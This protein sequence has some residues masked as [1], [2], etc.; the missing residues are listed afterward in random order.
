MQHALFNRTQCIADL[1]A[2][3]IKNWPQH[4]W[5][6]SILQHF[7]ATVSDQKLDMLSNLSEQWLMHWQWLEQPCTFKLEQMPDNTYSL[8][9]ATQDTPFL[10]DSINL[11]FRH[12]KLAVSFIFH[13]GHLTVTRAHQHV[14]HVVYQTKSSDNKEAWVLANVAGD[15]SDLKARL[16]QTCDQLK[17]A[18]SHFSAM[19][20]AAMSCQSALPEDCLKFLTWCL[21]SHFVLM[22][23]QTPTKTWGIL[24]DEPTHLMVHQALV[25]LPTACTALEIFKLP[26]FAP[27]HR[28]S[29]MDVIRVTLNAENT[30]YWIGLFTSSMERTPL[31]AIPMATD[32]FQWLLQQSQL[33]SNSHAGKS[34]LDI[35]ET[36]PRDEWLHM[37]NHDILTFA[38]NCIRIQPG[39]TRVLRHASYCGQF[40]SLW[41]YFP[42]SQYQTDTLQTLLTIVNQH[43]QPAHW[44]EPLV[45]HHD[46]MVC[47]YWRMAIS[48]D[49][50]CH[51][52]VLDEQLY[53]TLQSWMAQVIQLAPNLEHA[54]AIFPWHY[55]RQFSPSHAV[56]DAQCAQT[57]HA[58]HTFCVRWLHDGDYSMRWIWYQWH[59]PMALSVT[60]PILENF[61]FL[62]QEEQSFVL[63][64]NHQEVHIG[65]F[66]VTTRIPVPSTADRAHVIYDAMMAVWHRRAP[67]DSLNRLTTSHGIGWLSINVLRAYLAYFQQ[68]A[69][70]INRESAQATLLLHA[71][72]AYYLTQYFE[73]RFVHPSTVPYDLTALHNSMRA[74]LPNDEKCFH[75]YLQVMAA[76]VRT[77]FY[78]SWAKDFLCFKIHTETLD[79]LPLPR[80]LYEIWVDSLSFSGVHLRSARVARGG[81][82]WS[83]RKDDFRT[84][85]LGLMK[86]QCVKNTFIVPAGAKGGFIIKEDG[87]HLTPA[88]RLEWGVKFYKKF[89][90]ALLCLTDNIVDGVIIPPHHVTCHDAPDTYL[91]VAADKGTAQFSDIANCIAQEHQFWLDDAFASG[92]QYGYNHKTMGITAAGAWTSLQQHAYT[93]HR[94]AN[95]HAWTVIGI[96]DMAGDVFGNGMLLSPHIQLLAAFNGKHIFLN[97]YPQPNTHEEL[98]KLFNQPYSTWLDFQNFGEGGGVFNRSAKEITLHDAVKRRFNLNEHCLSPDALIRQLLISPVDIIWN[99]GIGTFVKACHESHTQVSDKTNDAIRVNGGDLTCTMVIE[100]GNLGMTQLGRIEYALKG[101]DVYADF[102]DN[103][104]GVSCSDHEVLLKILLKN[105]PNLSFVERNQLLQ[106][107]EPEIKTMVLKA[108]QR[109]AQIIDLEHAWLASHQNIWFYTAWIQ[110]LVKAVKLNPILEGLPTDEVLEERLRHQKSFTQPELAILLAYTKMLIKQ[111]ILTSDWS[112]LKTPVMAPFLNRFFPEK[113][114]SLYQDALQDHPLKMEII[115]TALTNQIVDTMGIT[116]IGRLQAETGATPMACIIAYLMCDHL[117]QIQATWDI[118]EPLN[119]VPHDVKVHLYANL[120]RSVRRCAR[121][122]LA[123]HAPYDTWPTYRHAIALLQEHIIHYVKPLTKDYMLELKNTWVNAQV[124][125]SLAWRLAITMADYVALD[126]TLAQHSLQV[127]AQVFLETYFHIGG[128]LQLGWL[129]RTLSEYPAHHMLDALACSALRDDLDD[130]QRTLTLHVLQHKQ[131]IE[132][133]AGIEHWVILLDHVKKHQTWSCYTI[134]FRHLKTFST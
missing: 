38:L 69:C 76:T 106:Q 51:W 21:S 112:I 43:A 10:V 100:G 52:T 96:G 124:P 70:G 127:D 101:G 18:V 13:T 97:P 12:L 83:D 44:T 82:R 84:E 33:D 99:G 79:V 26:V 22:G 60:M 14:Q 120:V 118:M 49:T 66:K 72:E 131:P 34:F 56:V 6:S 81:I 85:I 27:L 125:E 63:S 78:T 105:V 55:Q 29:Y 108:N 39:E 93:H 75:I 8:Y 17:W 58:D 113:A 64:F 45:K 98:K 16:F 107:C 89:I 28:S 80:P 32:R 41:L 9:F 3:L 123:H 103:A 92:G 95:T 129:R 87:A 53:H 109:Q 37:S 24:C 126:I 23:C 119:H 4:T 111:T 71:N 90:H 134:A 46:H 7:S 61:G 115:A 59:K 42:S 122:F 74:M 30:L 62:L 19:K 57:L 31:L 91:V 114:T 1:Q 94:S 2:C 50:T 133:W 116:F 128:Y 20:Q 25:K 117:Y 54:H 11:L 40:M 67:S 104:A 65:V 110:T 86:A 5:L 47:V 130:L 77:N 88:E 36:L 15:V 102:I 121:W 35:L 68:I 73:K 48:V 132:T